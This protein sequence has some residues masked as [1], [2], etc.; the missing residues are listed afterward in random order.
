MKYDVLTI[1]GVVE[2]ISFHTNEGIIID[3]KKDL[4]RQKLLAFEYGAKIKIDKVDMTFGGGAANAAVC[5]SRLGLKTAC[6]ASIGADE[7]GKRLLNNFQKEKVATGFIH[8]SKSLETAYSFILVG[9][10]NEHIVFSNRG[11]NQDL[12]IASTKKLDEAKCIFV[13]SLSGNWRKDLTKIFKIKKAKIAWNPGHRQL[14]GGIKILKPFLA[15]TN[16]L[17]VNKDEA[18]EI[19]LPTGLCEGQGNTCV[20]DSE[21][22]LKILKSF[23]PKIVVITEGAKGAKCYDG[24]KIYTQKAVKKKVLN[25]TGVGDA[26][27]SS[28]VAGLELYKG[29]IVKSLKLAALNSASV[30]SHLGAQTGLIK[31]EVR[32]KK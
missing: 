26:F 5:F 29:D 11:A 14:I 13:S 12:K 6:L 32:R 22:L 17:I 23:G 8:K 31:L 1:G 3:N 24:Q 16:V 18:L 7:R 21:Y 28:F 15:K 9:P 25:T 4:L 30:V 2:D 27:G 20:N 10:S 19:C